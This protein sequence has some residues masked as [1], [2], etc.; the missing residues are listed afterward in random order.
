[1]I[2][3]VS[4]CVVLMAGVLCGSGELSNRRAPSFALPSCDYSHSYDLLDY[5]GKVLLIDIMTTTC[6]H[7]ELLTTTLEKVGKKYGD[8]VAVLSVVVPPDNLNTV[9]KYKSVNRVTAPIACDMGQ[10]TIS[11]MNA[12]PGQGSIDLPHLFLIDKQ[13]TIRNDW[14]YSDKDK[15]VFEGP[16]LYPEVDKLLK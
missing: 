7:C 13:G 9:T 11:Y 10:M 5:R 2:R 15:G 3:R 16:A 8:K 12:K 4:C 1:M 6:P 14:V